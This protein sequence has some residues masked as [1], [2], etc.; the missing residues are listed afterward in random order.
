MK[1]NIDREMAACQK[2]I[3]ALTWLAFGQGEMKKA[4]KRPFSVVDY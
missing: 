3:Q 1:T 2:F 4:A